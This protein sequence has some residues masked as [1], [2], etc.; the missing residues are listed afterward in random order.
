M[1]RLN[2]PTIVEDWVR[3]MNDP[4]NPTFVRENYRTQLTLL[5]EELDRVL[6]LNERETKKVT[7]R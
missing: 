7:A 3:S 1:Q 5:R 6:K 2:I 4:S